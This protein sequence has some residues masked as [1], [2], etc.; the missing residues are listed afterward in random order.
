MKYKKC[1]TC[2]EIKPLTD[3]HKCK[4]HLDGYKYACKDCRNKKRREYIKT[5]RSIYTRMKNRVKEHNN[6]GRKLQ[7]LFSA[8][9]F[10][11]WYESQE[12]KCFYCDIPEKYIKEIPF[13]PPEGFA[14]KNRLEIDRLDNK[15]DYHPSNCVLAC[16]VC[17]MVKGAIL[18]E[19]EMKEVGKIINKKWKMKLLA[20]RSGYGF[21]K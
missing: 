9:E 19:L 8:E 1:T 2:K 4:S 14:K 21:V 5:P 3:F 6:K 20:K 13:C 10:I 16:P 7:M 11:M 18:N 17:N 12:K 15:F